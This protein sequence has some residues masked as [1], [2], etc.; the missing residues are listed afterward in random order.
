[1]NKNTHPTPS[2]NPQLRSNPRGRLA[3]RVTL[4]FTLASWALAAHAAWACSTPAAVCDSPSLQGFALIQQARPATVLVEKT[5]DPAVQRAAQ[6]FANDL[7]RISGRTAPL[8]HA[9]HSGI[10]SPVLIGVVGQSPLVDGLVRAGKLDV[11]DIQ[12]QWEAFKIVVVQQPWPQVAQALVIVGADR[13]GAMYGAYDVSEKAGVSPWHWFADVPVPKRSSLYVLA[14]SRSDQPGVR[15]RGFFINDEDPALGG[16]AQKKFGGTNAK[17]YEHVFDLLLRMKGNYIWPAMW[18]PRAFHLDDPRNTALADAMGVVMGSSHHEPLTRA[19]HEWHRLS[20]ADGAGGHWNYVSNGDNLRK[21]WRGG[22]ERMVSKGKGQSYESLITM[23]MRGDGDE[24]MSQDTAIGLLEKIVADQRQIIQDVTRKPAAQTPQMWALYKEVQDYYDEGMT[25]PD[26][27]TLL[28]ADDNW[29]QIRRLP[30][31]DLQRKGGFGVY[32]HFDYVGGPRNYKW[33]NTVQ[34]EKV[35]QQMNLAYER[36]AKN[37]WIVNVGDIK[38]MEYPLDFFMKMA[39]SPAAMTPAALAQFPQDWAQRQF[40]PQ[41]ASAIGELMTRYSQYAARRKPE[42]INET[43]YPVGEVSKDA[44][45]RGDYEAM[46]DQWR[47]LAANTK[48]LKASLPVQQHDAYFQ[49]LEYPVLALQNLHELY[50][51]SAWNRRL[52]GAHDARANY[53]IKP[54]QESFARDAELTAQYHRTHHGKWD[55]MM[56][57]I[58]MN[59]VIWNE[60]LQH[61]LPSLTRVAADRPVH[62]QKPEAIFKPQPMRKKN[63]LHKEASDFSMAQAQ[64][65]VQNANQSGLAWTAIPHLG[66]SKAAMVALPQGR[67]AT[68]IED[69][70]RLDY[71]FATTQASDVQVTLHLSPTLDTIG[72]SG[73]RVGMSIDSG[74][75]QILN[76]HLIPTA[77]AVRSVQQQH[78][79]DGVIQNRHSVAAQ[80]PA[81]APGPHT[82]KVWRLDDNVVLESLDIQV[83]AGEVAK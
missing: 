59:Y 67:P 38:P 74:A 32:Y 61:A 16:W 68:R 14:G 42:L 82:L 71:A 60:P 56:R 26:D 22:I 28:F 1:M 10:G 54:A 17:M 21:F 46:M 24:P 66:Q 27:V 58:H 72:A 8:R 35:W 80:F 30:T 43:T 41:H 33:L 11:A 34:I 79:T 23:G 4:R 53:F 57:Q 63:V 62:D 37:I 29:G 78:W 5:N 76:F 51:A 25:V 18:A 50:F 64:I 75:V 45:Y 69:D 9:L 7:Q 47:N 13:R 36:G 19:Q 65:Q 77:G 20:A 83:Q 55:G 15:Y 81:I 3:L 73:I 2:T 70:V 12:G 49:L 6:N 40:G 31:K 48:N 52:A 39:W 44:L